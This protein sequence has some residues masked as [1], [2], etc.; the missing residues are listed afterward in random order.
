APRWGALQVPRNVEGDSL[1][2]M[3]RVIM[4]ILPGKMG[5]A[6][7][8]FKEMAMLMAKKGLQFPPMRRYTPFMGGGDTLHTMI[9]EMDMDTFAEVAEFYEKSMA[10]PEI[11]GLMP[12]WDTVEKSHRLELYRVM[13]EQ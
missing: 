5:E 11:M 4:N 9:L 7:E 3:L 12:K 13:P 1:R 2:V 8:L 10:D 6:T